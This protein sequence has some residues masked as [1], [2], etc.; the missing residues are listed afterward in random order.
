[1]G[2]ILNIW[3]TIGLL[4]CTAGMINSI[5]HENEIIKV[6]CHDAWGNVI[7]GQSCDK[8]VLTGNGQSIETT[9]MI[10]FIMNLFLTPIILFQIPYIAGETNDKK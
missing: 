1:M 7:I 3:A 4:I 8:E 10:L 6:N 9:L 5:V 2:R